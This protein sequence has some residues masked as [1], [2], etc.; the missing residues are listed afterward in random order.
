MNRETWFQ[1]NWGTWF[2]VILGTCFQV[3]LGTSLVSVC[4]SVQKCKVHTSATF[5]APLFPSSATGRRV[6][7]QGSIQAKT[8]FA[9]VINIPIPSWANLNCSRQKF[10]ILLQ[11]LWMRTVG[12]CRAVVHRFTTPT[13]SLWRPLK[14][15]WSVQPAPSQHGNKTKATISCK[16]SDHF[17][18]LKIIPKW[19]CF[20]ILFANCWSGSPPPRPQ[21]T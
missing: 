3:N 20:E 17:L 1:V 5:Q 18:S 12:R 11:L 14:F 15:R 6:I 16:I 19:W 13:L 4:S 21:P 9:L 7:N 10:L 2:Q 8:Q